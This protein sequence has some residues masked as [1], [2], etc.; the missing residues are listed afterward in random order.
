MRYD[1]EHKE[2]TRARVL[3]A[4]SS[5]LREAGP[6]ALGVSEVMARVGLTHGGFYAHFPSKQALVAEAVGAAFEGGRRLYER[7]A[8]GRTPKQALAA[9]IGIYLSRTHR[10]GRAAGCPLPTL[11]ADLP[12]LD[13]ASRTQFRE[14]LERL[15]ARLGEMISAAGREDAD[16]LAGLVVSEMVGAVALARAVGPGETSDAI[17]ARSRAALLQRLRLEPAA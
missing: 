13:D 7:A 4:A 12:R 16:A 17:L 14:G 15:T 6:Q 5:A 8:E 2:R 1:A 3:E 11:A 9:Y 10:D